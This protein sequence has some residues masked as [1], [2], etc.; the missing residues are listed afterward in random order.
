MLSSKHPHNFHHGCLSP[1]RLTA[2]AQVNVVVVVVVV[3]DDG[4][5]GGDDDDDDDAQN[6]TMV[7]YYTRGHKVSSTCTSCD[8]P[9]EPLRLYARNRFQLVRPSDSNFFHIPPG[10]A[11][12]SYDISVTND[13]VIYSNAATY[14]V[15]DSNC[16]A[17]RGSSC[18][19]RVCSYLC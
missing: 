2:S 10:G 7:T 6:T 17:C 9:L 18:F 14:T 11:T 5:G 4:D 1:E 15:Y 13:D 16:M 8:L 12:Q 19:Q 3:D